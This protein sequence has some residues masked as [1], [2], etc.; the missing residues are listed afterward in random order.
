M[1]L[2][3]GEHT[4]SES[5]FS[6]GFLFCRGIVAAATVS[7]RVRAFK[8]L[9]S[10]LMGIVGDLDFTNHAGFSWYCVLLLASGVILL[11][12]AVLPGLR[13]GRRVLNVLVGLGF[14]G[15]AVYLTFMFHGG[16]YVVFFQTFILPI[17]LIINSFRGLRS[18]NLRRR[19][20][21]R[22]KRFQSAMSGDL[23][24]EQAAV[25]AALAQAHAQHAATVA[26]QTQAQAQA[27]GQAAD[28]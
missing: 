11:G 15:Y 8:A 18:G 13:W 21:R 20:A 26:A 9:T 28:G 12:L 16:T 6:A 22:Q 3:P 19:A 24:R 4:E 17:L 10:T 27:Q 23:A 1:H 2:R 5:C 14:L 25:Q 7:A